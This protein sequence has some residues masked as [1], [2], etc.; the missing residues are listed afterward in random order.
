MTNDILKDLKNSTGDYVHAGVGAALSSIP[1]VGSAI[2]ELFNLVIAPPLEKRRDKWLLEIYSSLTK[3]E[4]R[5]DDFKVEDLAKNEMFISVFMHA[6][7]LALKNHQPEKLMVLHNA[8]INTAINTSIEETEQF[9]FL[10][11][12]DDLSVWHIKILYYFIDPNKW[13]EENK[14][15][16]H[17]I[18]MGSASTA[19]IAAYEELK[20]KDEFINMIIR[21]LYNY[22]LMQK[23]TDGIMSEQGIYA[24]RTT[25]FGD[26]FLNYIMKI[27][28]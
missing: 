16:K 9:L 25:E 6:T 1:F 27:N 22:G 10:K 3:L 11:M 4:N 17:N 8:V 2:T 21:D 5:I 18:Y 15:L 24:K 13:Y 20:N 12:I 7:Q 28:I 19:L 14:K 23:F 26:K